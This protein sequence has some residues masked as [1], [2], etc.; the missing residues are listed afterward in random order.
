MVY[1][2]QQGY[3]PR[4]RLRFFSEPPLPCPDWLTPDD[5][6]NEQEKPDQ[7]IQPRRLSDS[8]AEESATVAG[9][10]SQIDE[11]D[12][13]PTPTNRRLSPYPSTPRGSSPS[14]LSIGDDSSRAIGSSHN[15]DGADNLTEFPDYSS[16]DECSMIPVQEMRLFRGSEEGCTLWY[17]TSGKCDVLHPPSTLRANVGELYIHTNTSTG[18]VRLWLKRREDRWS[19]VSSQDPHPLLKDRVLWLRSPNEPSWVTRDTYRT[20]AGRARRN[21][22]KRQKAR[23]FPGIHRFLLY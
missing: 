2:K 4:R 21:D 13:A 15:R 9:T 6:H 1:S 7:P 12:S 14:T 20:Y 8:E 3:T 17:K 22:L 11:P 23:Q 10:S 16:G 19:S 18:L 5:F